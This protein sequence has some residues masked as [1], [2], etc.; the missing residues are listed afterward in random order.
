M[1]HAFDAAA[2]ALLPALDLAPDL[3]RLLVRIVD[4]LDAELI[5]YTEI[6]VIQ[7]GDTEDAIVH[8]LGFSPLTEPI[9]GTRYGE[10]GFSPHWDWLTAHNGWFEMI[11]TFGGAFACILLIADQPGVHDGLRELCREYAGTKLV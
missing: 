7:P 6:V 9:A 2:I 4:D 8:A 3:K 5:G 1:L 10:A 11:I